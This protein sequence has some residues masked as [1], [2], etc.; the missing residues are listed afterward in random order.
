MYFYLDIPQP[1]WVPSPLIKE[2]GDS[3][4]CAAF[5][6]EALNSF[7]FIKNKSEI[8]LSLQTKLSFSLFL[9]F[10]FFL[11]CLTIQTDCFVFSII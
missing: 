6:D 10:F 5:V 8:I 9:F 1:G 7:V 3:Y 4:L 11:F 2:G